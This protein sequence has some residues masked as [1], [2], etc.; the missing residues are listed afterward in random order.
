MLAQR[1]VV[2]SLLANDSQGAR[3]YLVAYREA[4]GTGLDQANALLHPRQSLSA[5]AWG[6]IT[7]P[8]LLFS[9]RRMAALS[10]DQAPEELVAALARNIVT[11]GYRASRGIE[12]LE[13][14]EYL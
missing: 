10:T 7:I 5:A 6:P 9:F 1:L 8:G 14:T 2:L 11:S 4:G 13:Q 12:S 3:R